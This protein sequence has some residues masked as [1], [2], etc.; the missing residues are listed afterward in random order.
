MALYRLLIGNPGV[1]KSTLANCMAKTVLFKSGVSFGKGMTYQL[2]Q[3]S[4]NGVTYLDTPGLADFKIRKEAA[5]AITQGLKKGG[6]YQIFFVVTLESGRLR[7]EDL[8]TIKLV[9]ENAKKITSYSLIINKLSK[10]LY[11]SL[12]EDNKKEIKN[13]AEELVLQVGKNNSSP[14]VLLL[15]NNFTLYDAENEVV[16]LNDLD[17]FVSNAPSVILDPNLVKDIPGDEKSFE[18][19]IVLVTEELNKLRSN[20]EQMMKQLKTTEEKY[21]NTA[22]KRVK[23][24]YF[25]L[26]VLFTNFLVFL[27]FHFLYSRIFFFPFCFH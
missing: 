8:A 1:G 27:I 15:M 9:L 22:G 25:F 7:P 3:N 24:Y 11:D 14:K 20:K 21:K 4:H 12:H 10:R 17:D 18:E 5:E 23:F 13:L 26:I 2:D 19:A 6:N 16:T